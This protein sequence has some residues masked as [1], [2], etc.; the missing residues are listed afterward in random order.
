MIIRPFSGGTGFDPNSSEGLLAIANAHGGAVAE[1]AN[2]IVHPQTGILSTVGNTVKNGLKTF[3]DVLAMPNQIIAGTISS[4]YT[5]GEALEK[6]ISTS[7]VIFGER[8]PNASTMQKFGS[9]LVR[10]GTDI[11]L[12]PLTYVTFGAGRGAI[13]GAHSP[14]R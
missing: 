1:A 4:D 7:D 14:I 13:L 11:L 12:D 2:E 9:F 10:T 8:D 5:I 6:N 3:L